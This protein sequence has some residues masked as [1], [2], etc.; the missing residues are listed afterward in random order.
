MPNLVLTD[1][2]VRRTLTYGLAVVV[3]ALAIPGALSA[4]LTAY[5]LL[6]RSSEPNWVLAI[7]HL[8]VNTGGL[9]TEVLGFFGHT[10]PILLGAICFRTERRDR[11]STPGQTVYGLLLLGVVLSI[12]GIW[13]AHGIDP[14][15]VDLGGTTVSAIESA[16]EAS[17]RLTTTNLALLLGLGISVKEVEP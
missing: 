12:P 15:N 4:V 6:S 2:F 7:G 9:P 13:L 3:F 1:R 10:L 5:Y 11:L 16:S 8:L 17:F 14:A